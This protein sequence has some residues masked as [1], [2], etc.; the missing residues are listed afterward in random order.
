MQSSW[1]RTTMID[2]PRVGRK[3][4]EWTL[5]PDTR[6]HTMDEFCEQLEGALVV[7]DRT[8]TSKF[9]L[10]ETP[11]DTILIR[12]PPREIIVQAKAKY[13]DPTLSLDQYEFPPFYKIDMVQQRKSG[14]SPEELFYSMVGDYTTAE[15]E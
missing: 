7:K 11:M 5:D 14:I 3:I 8:K 9:K 10:I 12:L 4:V 6:P 1:K 2:H 15:C 13:S